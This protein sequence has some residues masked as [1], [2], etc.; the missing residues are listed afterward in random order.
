MK[1]I[2]K[3]ADDGFVLLDCTASSQ[4]VSD[5]LNQASL[6]F[7][8]QMGLHPQQGKTPAQVASEQLGIKNLDEAVASQAVELIVPHAINKV[9]IVPAYMPTAEPKTR[10]GRGHAFQFDL[11]VF[12]KPRFELDDYG[13][14]KITVEPYTSDEELVDKQVADMARQFTQFVAADA[15]PLGT[16]DSC[17]LKMSTTKGGEEVPGLT[18]ESRPYTLGMDLM[19]VGFD[20]HL[21]GMEVGETRTFTFEG[22]GLDADFN[23]VMEEYET[24]VT[25]LEVQKEVVPVIDDA[26]VTANLPMYKSLEDMRESIRSDIDKERRKYYEDY[27]RNMAATE[28]AKRFHG[29]IPDAVYEGSIKETRANMHQQVTRQGLKWEEFVEQSGGE[30]QVNMMLMVEMRQQ[31]VLGF[32]LDAYYAH[33]GLAYT[34][35]DLDEVCFQMNPQN[36]KQARESMERNGFGY[37]LRESAERLRACKRLV[38]TADITV[39]DKPAS[40]GGPTVVAGS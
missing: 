17:L 22:P 4:E 31:L 18:M 38:E 16:N 36:P 40:T 37:A 27:K 7:C 25:L 3:K 9:G 20:D 33:E 26:W 15:H 39:S 10:I 14:V 13:P 35:E 23:E 30:Q 5:A 21:V 12:P 2:K 29:T 1:V 24:T 8:Q 28:L 19:P 6:V 11:K 34:E 32:A